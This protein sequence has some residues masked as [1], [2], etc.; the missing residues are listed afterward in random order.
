MLPFSSHM[1]ILSASPSKE[2]PICAL[3]FFVRYLILF[4]KVDPHLSF[5]L[6]PLGVVPILFTIAPKDLSN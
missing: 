3:F 6:N 1:I 2:I 5:I 4:G